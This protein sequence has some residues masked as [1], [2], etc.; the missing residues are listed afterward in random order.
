M[1]MMMMMM[2]MMR[3]RMRMR[4][5]CRSDFIFILNDYFFLVLFDFGK[6]LL[7]FECLLLFFFLISFYL[8]F[9]LGIFGLMNE[10]LP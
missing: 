7:L 2:M 6:Y 8:S 5:R 1:M 3:M 4:R 9:E 10:V